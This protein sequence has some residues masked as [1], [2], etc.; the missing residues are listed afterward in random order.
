MRWIKEEKLKMVLAYKKN[1]FA[2]T[3]D[4]FSIE[5][6]HSRIKIWAKVYDIYDQN[7]LEHRSRHWTY[8]DRINAVQRI[9]NGES[10]HEVARSLGMSTETQVSTWHRKYL[11]LG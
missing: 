9:L 11:E 1:S 10:Y 7:G 6:M 4:G 2:P 3:V 8:E 5:A